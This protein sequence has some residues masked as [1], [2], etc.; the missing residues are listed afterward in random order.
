MSPILSALQAHFAQ[1]GQSEITHVADNANM[2][3]MVRAAAAPAHAELLQRLSTLLRAGDG[4]SISLWETEQAQWQ[5]IF[6][7]AV[8]QEIHLALENIDFDQA[9]SLLAQADATEAT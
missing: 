3:D 2:S 6:T 7:P 5:Q 9:L 4:D 1:A 8:Y